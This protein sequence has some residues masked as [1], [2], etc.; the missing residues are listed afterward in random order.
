[1]FICRIKAGTK[2]KVLSP[3]PVP[4]DGIVFFDA[5]VPL[6]TEGVNQSQTPLRS[7]GYEVD[8]VK[9]WIATNRY[10]LT[11]EQIAQAYK[12]RWNI[13]NFFAWWKRHLKVYRLIA[14]GAY[15]L[16]VQILAGL[17]AYLLPAIYCHKNFQEKVSIR[18]VGRL[19]TA[20]ENE[21]RWLPDDDEDLQYVKEQE[22][23][24]VDA[25]T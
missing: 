7:V 21:P 3:K 14:R 17:I 22:L 8:R 4:A 9:Y 13:E 25:K 23:Q 6:G 18:R 2:K 1:M 24:F 12:P 5:T 20:I 15:G 11:G 10:D 16:M 19:R